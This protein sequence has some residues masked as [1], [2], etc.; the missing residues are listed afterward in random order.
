MQDVAIKVIDQSL[1]TRSFEKVPHEWPSI[2]SFMTV[3]ANELVQAHLHIQQEFV[4]LYVF[5]DILACRKLAF[6]AN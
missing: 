1:P 3:Y 6:Y 4:N 5:R 2:R